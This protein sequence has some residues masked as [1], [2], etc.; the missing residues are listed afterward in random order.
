MSIG[1]LLGFLCG[2]GL[3]VLSVYLNLGDADWM[4]FISLSSF[5]IV[6]G[7]TIA[8]AY[9]CYQA[10]Y[11]NQS[12]IELFRI[13]GSART[14]QKSIINEVNQ[15]LAWADIAFK[16]G[17][18]GLENHLENEEPNEHLLSFGVD[19]VLREYT[20][21]DVRSLMSNTIESEYQRVSVQADILDNMSSNAPAFGMIGTLVGLVIMLT[22]LNNPEQLGSAMAIALLTTLYGVLFSRLLFQPS[23]KKVLQR[24]SIQRFRNQVIMEI[25]V[26][27]REERPATFVRN[28]VRSFLRPSMLVQIENPRNSSKTSDE[29]EEGEQEE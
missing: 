27:I 24:A 15:C 5:L 3:F 22:N 9:I 28:R 12:L 8:N 2:I 13:F 21:E 10:T 4:L 11:V 19:L 25:F 16:S 20:P 1:T 29:E 14:S 23:S 6:F 18:L 26:M 7:G 17:V